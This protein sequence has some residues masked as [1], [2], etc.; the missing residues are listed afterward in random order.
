MPYYSDIA[1]I[2]DMDP[3]LV[4]LT[5]DEYARVV[6]LVDSLTAPVAALPASLEWRS[7]ARDLYEQRLGEAIELIGALRDGYRRAAQAVTDYAGAQAVAKDHVATGVAAQERLRA[8]MNDSGVTALFSMGFLSD[9]LLLWETAAYDGWIPSPLWV[10][11]LRERMAPIQAD[12]EAYYR[13]ATGSFEQA[14]TVEGDARSAAVDELTAAYDGLPSFRAGSW[15]DRAGVSVFGAD[16]VAAIIAGTP[17][18]QAEAEQAASDPNARRPGRDVVDAYQVA[19]DDETVRYPGGWRG[20]IADILFGDREDVRGSEA[21][22]LDELST[23][24]LLTFRDIRDE[25][26]RVA[27]M[28]F[29]A[30]GPLPEGAEPGAANLS[31]NHLDAFRHTYWNARMTQEFGADWTERFATAHET[32][33]GTPPV[34]GAM[35]MYNNNLGRSIALDHPDAYPWEIA[36]LV[37]EAVND[38]RA[39]VIGSDHQLHFSDQVAHDDVGHDE[40]GAEPAPG[41]IPV[42]E[43]EY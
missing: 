5:A 25:A 28:R 15:L 7:G 20:P 14:L 29:T 32:L 37:E 40:A 12:G 26:E 30:E 9:P 34:A 39:T 24:E 21:E 6:R 2:D 10:E 18:L 27:G 38:G 22:V 3:V 16:P 4:R 41:R 43:G 31:D 11:A 33:P 42:P 8:L 17:G 19:D 36:A 1:F 23:S 35:D 13:T